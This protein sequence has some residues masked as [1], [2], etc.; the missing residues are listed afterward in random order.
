[1]FIKLS[2]WKKTLQKKHD[3][4]KQLLECQ[5]RQDYYK[6]ILFNGID[7]FI[8]TFYKEPV[9]KNEDGEVIKPLFQTLHIEKL[10]PEEIEEMLKNVQDSFSD[11][12]LQ[13]IREK[14]LNEV[15]VYKKADLDR[16]HFSKIRSN[17]SYRPTK[18]TVILLCLSMNLSFEE[19]QDLLQRAG[20]TLSRSSKQDIIAEY[21]L[22]RKIYDVLLY[23]EVLSNYGFIKE[24]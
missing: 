10:V 5:K 15:D 24:D 19:A 4:E 1:M 17:S 9:I 22:R 16:R 11:R 6:N 14:N 2:E 18:D 23:K 21:F 3:L 8:N 20:L 12:L 13:I 7:G